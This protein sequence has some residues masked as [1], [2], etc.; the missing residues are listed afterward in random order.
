MALLHSNV[1]TRG[2]IVTLLV[3]DVHLLQSFKD[4]DVTVV[5]RVVEAVEAFFV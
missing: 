2:A 5:R 4:L 1:Q 3:S